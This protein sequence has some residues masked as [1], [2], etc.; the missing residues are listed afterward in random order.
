MLTPASALMRD[1]YQ[2]TINPQATD[3]QVLLLT[4]TTK[5]EDVS[6]KSD[7]MTLQGITLDRLQDRTQLRSSLDRFRRDAFAIYG[8]E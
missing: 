8:E 7:G 2:K 3:R 6:K 1:V 4:R 5:L